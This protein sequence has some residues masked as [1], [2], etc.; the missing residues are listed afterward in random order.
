MPGVLIA[1]HALQ[2][3]LLGGASDAYNRAGSLC[4]AEN[5]TRHTVPLQ[6]V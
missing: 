5:N 4:R 6:G 2:F 1:E 3:A